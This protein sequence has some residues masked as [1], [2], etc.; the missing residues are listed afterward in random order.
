[1]PFAFAVQRRPRGSGDQRALF[2]GEHVGHET[3]ALASRYVARQID[4]VRMIAHWVA[5]DT[6]GVVEDDG[7]YGHPDNRH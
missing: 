4:P 6:L 3:L 1:M 5:V 7:R 2:F